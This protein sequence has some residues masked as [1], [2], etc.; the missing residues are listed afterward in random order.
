MSLAA[1]GE[2][3]A[4]NP[5]TVPLGVDDDDDDYEPDFYAAEDTE[6]ILNKLD[7]DAPTEEA[8][9]QEA[10]SLALGTFTLPPPPTIDP[11]VAAKVGQVAVSRV[12]GPLQFLEDPSV[13]RTKAGMNRL[14]ASSYDKDS[15][16]TVIMRLATRSSAGLEEGRQIKSEDAG[17]GM[18]VVPAGQRYRLSD[19]FR[20]ALYTY[21]L[22]NFRPRIEIAV[23]WLCEEW[24]C[25]QLAKR[26][27]QRQNPDAVDGPVLSDSERP[28]HYETWTLRVVDGFLPYLTPQD[29]VLTR[30]L[31]E[32]PELSRALLDRVKALCRD[33][34][35]VN[36]A[37]TSLLY[38]VMMRPPV[39]ELALDTVAGIWLECELPPI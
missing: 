26:Q 33:P 13:K 10:D 16:L 29:K 5:D 35:M 39:R 31:G 2:P 27:S 3:A 4:L 8:I 30:F 18:E 34:S 6:Q 28:L 15:W 37:L 23:A 17:N 9:R 11:E 38:L 36:L 21:V 20:E 14:A 7:S 12:F 19:A 1:A 24:Y 32:I 22:E 25:D